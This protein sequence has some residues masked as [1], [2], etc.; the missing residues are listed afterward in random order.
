M[1]QMTKTATEETA[2]ASGT[3]PLA[4]AAAC[5]SPYHR[6]ATSGGFDE[7]E[8]GGE[9]VFDGPAKRLVGQMIPYYICV[10]CGHAAMML[11]RC[12]R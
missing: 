6:H 11:Y 1:K 10:K 2:K 5:R 9:H 3:G 7:C 12:V 4:A 8:V